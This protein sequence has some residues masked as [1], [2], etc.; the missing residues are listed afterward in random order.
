[1]ASVDLDDLFSSFSGQLKNRSAGMRGH[2]EAQNLKLIQQR[3]YRRYKTGAL[4]V[5]QQAQCAC[6]TKPEGFGNT[7]GERIVEHDHCLAPFQ[8]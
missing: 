7:S 4:G 5:Q 3:G 6:Q 1:M 8:P 2:A